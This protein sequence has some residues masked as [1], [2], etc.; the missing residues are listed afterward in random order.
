[1]PPKSKKQVSKKT[2]AVSRPKTRRKK[3]PILRRAKSSSRRAGG[4]KVVQKSSGGSPATQRPIE[5]TPEMLKKIQEKPVD[6]HG[7]SAYFGI[8][9]FLVLLFVGAATLGAMFF[10]SQDR[11]KQSAS[12]LRNITLRLPKAS[13][14]IE[15]ANLNSAQQA[16][17]NAVNTQGDCD[18]RLDCIV[19]SDCECETESRRQDRCGG[20]AA[21]CECSQPQYV[22]CAELVCPL[23]VSP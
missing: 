9:V 7:A 8:M 13:L 23:P 15:N 10:V 4:M 16:G 17:C 1:M 6:L 3:R 12:P 11:G 18:N 22:R 2:L 14:Q 5:L 20:E 19:V 21:S